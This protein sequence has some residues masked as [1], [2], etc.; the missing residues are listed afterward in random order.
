MQKSADGDDKKFAL[1]FWS[2]RYLQN[3][4]LNTRI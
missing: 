1:K 2:I 4:M 3:G